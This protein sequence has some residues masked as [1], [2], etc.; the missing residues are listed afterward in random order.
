MEHFF[1]DDY[2]GIEFEPGSQYN[3]VFGVGFAV[4]ERVTLSSRF[5]GAYVEELKANGTRL[6]NTNFEPM[7]MRFAATISKPCDR[8]V[9]PFVEFGLTDDSVSSFFGITWTY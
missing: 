2:R 8:I 7:T 5:F 9:E 1:S 4:N 6:F 3:Y